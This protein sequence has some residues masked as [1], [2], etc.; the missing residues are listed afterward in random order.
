MASETEDVIT[1]LRR[2]IEEGRKRLED[3][4]RALVVLES[5]LPKR[6]TSNPIGV[7]LISSVD[8][9]G[10]IDLAEIEIDSPRGKR[11]TLVDDV[12]DLVKRFGGQ[13]FTVAHTEKVLN[14]RGIEIPGKLPRSRISIVL[15]KLEEEGVIV[16]TFTGGGNVP[17]RYRLNAHPQSS[18]RAAP[19]PP[20]PI[21][22]IPEAPR[23]PQ[24]DE[25][26][27]ATNTEASV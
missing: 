10:I 11:R 1:Q 5:M 12:R 13:E 14:N 22:R 24:K 21:P 23:M 7:N 6:V 25:S 9:G 3:Q 27:S 17:N 4:E 20:P 16:K 26:P 8:D 15:G 2:A 18:I 19:V